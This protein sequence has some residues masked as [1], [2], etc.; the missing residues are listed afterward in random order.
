MMPFLT[1]AQQW[2]ER[3][4]ASRRTAADPYS[5]AHKDQWEPGDTAHFEY[6]CLMDPSSSDYHLWKRTQ[7]PVTVLG[8]HPQGEDFRNEL[9]TG[10]ERADEGLP[11]TYQ[12][13]FGDGHEDSATE[14]ELLVHPKHF[15]RGYAFL[16]ENIGKQGSLS[17]RR[18]AAATAGYL[19]PDQVAQ[20]ADPLGAVNSN[21]ATALALDISKNGMQEPIAIHTNGEKAWI[22]D[23]HH[24]NKAAQRLRLDRVPVTVTKR[25]QP[26]WADWA[27]PI[28][29]ELKQLLGG[30]Q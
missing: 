21:W 16:P 11:L 17:P 12:V 13:R 19:H 25:K 10:A 6:H 14:D 24:R 8:L 29:P 27:P 4:A 3:C 2:P 28:G 9:P 5:E 15:S 1:Q 23:G 22:Y 26:K 7:Q 30:P 18:T 20:Y